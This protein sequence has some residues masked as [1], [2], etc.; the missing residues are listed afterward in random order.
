MELQGTLDVLKINGSK[1]LYDYSP[2][3]CV[4]FLFVSVFLLP[5]CS[6]LSLGCLTLPVCNHVFV[7]NLVCFCLYVPLSVCLCMFSLGLIC[8]TLSAC[9]LLSRLVCMYLAF[10]VC[11]CSGSSGAPS[12]HPFMNGSGSHLSVVPAHGPGMAPGYTVS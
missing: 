3:V 9:L 10:C 12:S 8:I 4:F 6:S 1:V 11:V 2:P 7:Q 5:P